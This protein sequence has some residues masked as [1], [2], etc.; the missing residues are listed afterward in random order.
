MVEL[1]KFFAQNMYGNSA[2]VAIST[3][4]FKNGVYSTRNQ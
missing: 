1:D 4:I 3:F 2:L